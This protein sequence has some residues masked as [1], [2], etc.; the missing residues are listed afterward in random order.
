MRVAFGLRDGGRSW[1]A[2]V[3]MVTVRRYPPGVASGSVLWTLTCGRRRLFVRLFRFVMV[4]LPAAHGTVPLGSVSTGRTFGTNGGARYVGGS[5][6]ESFRRRLTRY[7]S[8]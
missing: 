6:I 7:H 2:L 3:V 5:L 1:F 4:T 8:A